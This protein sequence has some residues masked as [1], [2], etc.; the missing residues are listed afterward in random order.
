M[1]RCCF[2]GSND[3]YN[4]DELYKNLVVRIEK[5]VIEGDVDEFWVE[6]CDEFDELCYAAVNQVKEKYN[7]VKLCLILKNTHKE[8]EIKIEYDKVIQIPSNVRTSEP[9]KY[10]D[11]ETDFSIIYISTTDGGGVVTIKNRG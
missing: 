11:S 10:I 1:K 2:V 5:L 7:N 6:N 9:Y 3:I 8:M 4:K